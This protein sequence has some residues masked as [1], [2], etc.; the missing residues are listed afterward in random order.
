VSRVGRPFQG[1]DVRN[2]ARLRELDRKTAGIAAVA[3][4]AQEAVASGS[5]GDVG[6][7]EVTS[8]V[9]GLV[10]GTRTAVALLADVPVLAGRHYR[11][12]AV[13]SP[14]S[15]DGSTPTFADAFLLYTLDGSDPTTSSPVLV[16]GLGYYP[17]G[18]IPVTAHLTRRFVPGAD[19]PLSL[20]LAVTGQSGRA[21]AVAGSATA[22]IQVWVEDIG[23]VPA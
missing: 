16:Q 4:A 18:G 7:T 17:S 2:E 1:D 8:S 14:Y 21:H 15:T 23:P 20:L 12:H 9:T 11:V 19:A 5:L 13:L 10:G 6:W 22:P 3:Q